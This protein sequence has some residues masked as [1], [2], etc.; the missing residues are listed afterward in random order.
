MIA[1]LV[2]ALGRQ[3]RFATDDGILDVAV[4]LERM[5]KPKDRRISKQLQNGV[6]KILGGGEEER[7]QMRREIKQ[8]YDVRSAIIHGPKNE[9]KKQMLT[10]RQEAFC[11]GFDLARRS[12][13]KIL[14]EGTPSGVND[15][16]LEVPWNGSW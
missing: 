6:A 2:E 11:N 1:R 14:K 7:S 12:V 8:F 3:G 10:K 13:I 5:Y 9:Q 16:N 15:V 4:S